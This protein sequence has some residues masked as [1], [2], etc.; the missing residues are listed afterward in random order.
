MDSDKSQL[1]ELAYSLWNLTSDELVN[2]ESVTWKRLVGQTDQTVWHTPYSI[3]LDLLPDK[4]NTTDIPLPKLLNIIEELNPFE[5]ELIYN[6]ILFYLSEPTYQGKI[7]I[8]SSYNYNHNSFFAKVA[9]SD[10]V[11]VLASALSTNDPQ[12]NLLKESFL[13]IFDLINQA[14][15]LHSTDKHKAAQL[16]EQALG[17]ARTENVP[18]ALLELIEKINRQKFS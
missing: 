1:T 5:L 2:L 15:T 10:D 12:Q 18:G 3:E 7:R 14:I 13:K 4:A 9:E 6:C 16:V 8:S 17:L 11:I